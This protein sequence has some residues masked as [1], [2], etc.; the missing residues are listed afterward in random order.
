MLKHTL[1]AVARLD[2]RISNASSSSTIRPIRSSAR[3][4]PLPRTR[5]ALQVHNVEK[6][7]LQ[8]GRAAHRDGAH[9]GRRRVIGI[10]DADYV[11]QPDWLKDLVP[12]FADPRVAWCKRRRSIATATVR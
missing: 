10:I 6:S 5:R 3:S 9:G 2:Y 8:G 12:V 4:R 7:R 11:V 1:D